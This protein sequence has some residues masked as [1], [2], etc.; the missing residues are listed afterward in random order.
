M[1]SDI[2][3]ILKEVEHGAI[4]LKKDASYKGDMQAMEELAKTTKVLAKLKEIII[5]YYQITFS[6]HFPVK[7]TWEQVWEKIPIDAR[8][9][10]RCR[11]LVGA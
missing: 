6:E 8:E 1:M 4:L 7:C 5:E 11:G 9:L 10:D 2:I 3:A